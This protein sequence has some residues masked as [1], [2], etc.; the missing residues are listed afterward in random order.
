MVFFKF[1]LFSFSA[2]RPM[3]LYICIKFHENIS[4]GFQKDMISK[5]KITKGH[6]SVQNVGGVTV[7]VLCILSSDALYLLKFHENIS[8][9]FRVIE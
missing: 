2:H 6:I 8:K 1:L 7:L 5:K 9:A 4:T 3:M